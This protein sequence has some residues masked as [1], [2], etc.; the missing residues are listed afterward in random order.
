MHRLLFCL[1]ALLGAQ[2]RAEFSPDDPR[3]Y[4]SQSLQVAGDVQQPQTYA[5]DQLKALP[6]HDL[7][8][9]LQGCRDS[10]LDAKY[11]GYRGVLLR[12]LVQRAAIAGTDPKAW[13]RS[14]VVAEASDGYLALFTWNE[15]FNTATGDA[16]LVVLS[17]DGQPLPDASGRIALI[18]GCDRHPGP[19]HVKWLQRVEV[20]VLAQ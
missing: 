20:R 18:S 7:H 12:D 11:R 4:V 5:L 1:L 9:L 19:R 3:P 14:L 16:V 8:Q 2:A 13:K 17:Q 6:G 10:A 15:L